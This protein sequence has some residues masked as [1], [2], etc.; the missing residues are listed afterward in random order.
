[1]AV[2]EQSRSTGATGFAAAELADLVRENLAGLH[3]FA[4]A[5]RFLK[6]GAP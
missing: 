5:E 3:P 4:T 2:R 6:G 1:M